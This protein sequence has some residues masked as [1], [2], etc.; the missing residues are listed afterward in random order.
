MPT[1]GTEARNN[2]LQARNVGYSAIQY[3]KINS[4]TRN[5]LRQY[6]QDKSLVYI[7]HD[8][9][10]NAGEHNENKVFDNIWHKNRYKGE[11]YK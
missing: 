4:F 6:M 1:A 11:I 8:V 7:Y 3:D 2:I 10:D 9:I 5:E